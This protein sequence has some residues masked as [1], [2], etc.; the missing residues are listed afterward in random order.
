VGPESAGAVPGPICYGKG[1]QITVTDANLCLGKLDPDYPLGGSLRL[2]VEKIVPVFQELARHMSVR[3]PQAAAQG[4]VDVAN[5]NMEAALRVISVERG[6][7]PR[8]FTLVTFGGAGGLHAADLAE[9]LSVPRV[10]IP[11]NP[12]LLSALGLLL[13][14]GVQDFSQTTIMRTREVKA[15]ELDRRYATLEKKGMASMR[16]EGFAPERIRLERWIDMRYRGQSFELSLP[17]SRRFQREFH[18]RHKQRYGYSDP[19]RESE[20]VTLRV[21][22]RGLAERPRIGKS[23]LG[24]A[25]PQKALIKEK[26]VC[27]KGRP[28]ATHVYER[29]LLRAGNRIVGPALIFEYSASTAIPPGYRCCVDS[30][31]NLVIEPSAT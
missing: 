3:T 16:Q 31:R 10:L 8:D 19:A 2:K 28:M 11:E 9:S 15:E 26:S 5:A 14:D 23:R 27:F 1:N 21:R 4:V 22:A 20:I 7:D 17:Y 29:S 18:R 6:F 12:G 24:S 25:S 30:F 13:S